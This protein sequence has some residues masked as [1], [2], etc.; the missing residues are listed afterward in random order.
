M[1][2]YVITVEG[3]TSLP[4]YNGKTDVVYRVFWRVWAAK[5]AFQGTHDDFTD[6]T[7]QHDSDFTPYSDLTQDIVLSWIPADALASAKNDVDAQIT[8]EINPYGQ[9]LPLPWKN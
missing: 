2:D 3:L 4:S 6:V 5:N 8:N 7:F 9:S 1:N